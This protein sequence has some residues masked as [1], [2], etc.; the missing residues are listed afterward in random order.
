MPSAIKQIEFTL[1]SSEVELMHKNRNTRCETTFEIEDTIKE[2]R[3]QSTGRNDFK[4]TTT[5]D[6]FTNR[7]QSFIDDDPAKMQEQKTTLKVY[8]SKSRVRNGQQ[9]KFT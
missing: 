4:I 5:R 9:S 8:E 7:A 1:N 3:V 6:L 2:M